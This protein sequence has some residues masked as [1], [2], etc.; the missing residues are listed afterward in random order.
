MYI[1]VLALWYITFGFWTFGR[2]FLDSDVFYDIIAV[3]TFGTSIKNGRLSH[4]TCHVIRPFKI[5]DSKLS[6]F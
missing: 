3:P 2:I 6:R 5:L 1:G 4:V